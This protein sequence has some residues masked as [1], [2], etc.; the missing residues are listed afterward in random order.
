MTPD[1]LEFHAW[2]PSHGGQH[3]GV[4]TGVLVRHVR[5]GMSWVCSS[6]PTR[7]ANQAVAVAKLQAALAVIAEASTFIAG[8]GGSHD[9]EEAVEEARCQG[10]TGKGSRVMR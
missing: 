7:M 4:R 3:A 5:T 10:L 9:L 1:E 2:P 8:P 6:E